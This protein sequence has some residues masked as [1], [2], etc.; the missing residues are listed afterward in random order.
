MLLTV[1]LFYP[2]P[3]WYYYRYPYANEELLPPHF[4]TLVVPQL[5]TVFW[6]K[7]SI[8]ILLLPE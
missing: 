2:N 4:R 3:A 7:F 5:F 8:Q 1:F 6:K